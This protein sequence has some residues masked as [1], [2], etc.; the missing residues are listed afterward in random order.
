ML[1]GGAHSGVLEADFDD[2]TISDE[3]NA[4]HCSVEYIT[5]ELGAKEAPMYAKEAPMYAKEAPMY[6]YIP[7]ARSKEPRRP[8]H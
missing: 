6:A 5:D 3:I 7:H 8:I 2:A 1:Q 4:L